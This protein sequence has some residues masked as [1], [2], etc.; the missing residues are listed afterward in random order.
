MR[1]RS[2][3]Q[4]AN[5][6]DSDGEVESGANAWMLQFTL[7]NSLELKREGDWNLFAGYKYIQPDALPDGF[8]DSSF[9]LAGTNAKGYFLGGNY[10]LASNV[11]ATGRWLSSKRC[12][13]RRT[14]SMSCSLKSTRASKRRETS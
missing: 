5:N 11:F 12:T 4:F 8:N 13:A 2:A 6:L 9:H 10:G 14:T 3:G 1:K 7:G